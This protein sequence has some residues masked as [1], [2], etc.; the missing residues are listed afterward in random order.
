MKKNILAIALAAAALAGTSSCDKVSPQGV[1]MA[2]TGVDDRVKMSITYYT[3]TFDKFSDLLVDGEEYTFLIG[4]DSHVTTDTMRMHEMFQIALDNND[5]FVVHLGD[6]ADTKPEYYK[7]LKEVVHNFK[8]N[9]FYKNFAPMFDYDDE[10]DLWVYREN[11]SLKMT[12]ENLIENFVLVFFPVVGN[13]DITHNGWA[14]WSDIFKSSFYEF[15]VRS[16]INPENPMGNKDHFIFLDSASGTLGAKQIDAINAGMLDFYTNNDF[17]IDGDEEGQIDPLGGAR[18][19]FL[20]SHTNLF[21]PNTVQFA[22]T[23]PRE[24]MYYILDCLDRWNVSGMFCGHVH[25]W[26]DR[27]IGTVRYVT[28]DSM[29]ERNSPHAGDYLVRVHVRGNGQWD[30]EKVRMNYV[31]SK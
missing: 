26:D 14:L 6:I 21:R 15:N 19:T 2:G 31:A 28:L 7:L 13:H 24:E 4:A 11:P 30:I 23:F 20:F 8:L 3:D 22:S 5:L 9:Y 16:G 29:S 1:L 25:A 17:I 27:K 10:S 18:H 12:L